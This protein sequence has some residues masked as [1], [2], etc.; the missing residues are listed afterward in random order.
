M[1]AVLITE[2]GESRTVEVDGLDSLQALV[3]GFI[4]SLSI[5]RPGAMAWGNDEAKLIGLDANYRATAMV[6]GEDHDEAVQREAAAKAEWEARGFAVIDA[7][8]G[9][10]R[11]PYIAGPIVVTGVS[12][13]GDTLP[14]PADLVDELVGP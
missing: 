1:R 10:P 3:G 12:A 2:D 6:Y 4:E 8:T 9:D 14:C 11:E 13:E 5:G 7:G